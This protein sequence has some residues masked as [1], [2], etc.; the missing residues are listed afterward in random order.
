MSI[1]VCAVVGV[2]EGNGAA[3]A[4]AF[5]QT[6]LAVALLARRTDFT[7]QLAGSL[8]D[9]RAYACDASD[10]AMVAEAFARIREELGDPTTLIY[11]AGPGV[12]GTSRA[13][14]STPSRPCG[15]PMPM[16]LWRPASRSSRR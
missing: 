8:P 3:L 14:A 2:G 7:G 4:R 6:G 9:A 16:R 12:W 1:P 10:P 15:G 13:S 5:A 11:N